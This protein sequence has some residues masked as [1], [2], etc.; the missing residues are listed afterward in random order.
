MD[1]QRFD[2][3]ARSLAMRFSRRRALRHAGAAASAGVFAAAGLRLMP[4]AAQGDGQPVYTV[5]RRYTLGGQ[6][7]AVRQALQ[8]GYL[9]D[10]C[11]APGFMAY[12]TVE[13]E[14]GDFV[15]F[16]VFGTQQDFENFANAEATWIAQNLSN[17]LPAPDEVISGQS[18]IHVGVPQAFAG[19]CPGAPTAPTQAPAPT[20]APGQPTSTAAPPAPTGAPVSPTPT[21]LPACTAQGCVCATGTQAP[22]DAGLVCCPTT[23]VMGGPGVCQTQAVCYPNQCTSNG[24]ACAATCN[25]GDACPSC[26]SNFCNSGGQCDNL[27]VGCTGAGCGCTTGTQSPC[28]A[29][30]ICCG[31]TGTPGGPGICTAQSDCGTPCTA[32]NCACDPSNANACDQGLTCCAVQSGYIC[33][34]SAQ[35]GPAPC[36]SQGC[37]C[38]GGVQGACDDGLVCCL[39]GVQVIGGNGGCVPES[40]CMAPTVCTNNSD[41]CDA[42][43]NWGDSC[44]DCCSGYCNASGQCDNQPPAACTSQG[45]TCF[46]GVQGACDPGLV[47]CLNGVAVIG[48]NGGC[49]PEAQCMPAPCTSQGCDC[50][51]GVEGA[52]DAGLIC[53]VQGDP[54]APGTCQ[55]EDA[56][57]GSLC[58]GQGCDCTSDDDCA[59][60]LMCCVQG[61]PG[62]PGTCQTMAAC[63]GSL[64][65]G[66]GCDC[67]MDNPS[68]QDGLICCGP[69]EAGAQGTCQ[70][71]DNCS[72]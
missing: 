12:F 25:W 40:Q 19:T 52:C 16:S 47:C 37:A 43:C 30:L 24:N 62:A 26:C 68:C 57:P 18:Y 22:C 6:A 56:C 41:G 14:D 64:C 72:G 9:D 53:C 32:A 2:N 55:T 21:P 61:D 23:D 17:L 54:G 50:T 69:D 4:V 15:T 33:I 10:V 28:D 49:V 46:G 3:L 5:V 34:S 60:G 11:N 44:T 51:G 1:A 63:P 35:C 13:D 48:G 71:Q 29:G 65:T 39:N 31:T 38:T 36:T 7:S 59:D 20:V 45:C 8:Q 70:S 58:T 67:A 42:S 27:P 66:E